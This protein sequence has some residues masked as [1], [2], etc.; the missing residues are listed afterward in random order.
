[1]GLGI[2]TASKSDVTELGISAGFGGRRG[3]EGAREMRSCAGE[4]R[5]FSWKA[6]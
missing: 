6:H 3:V 2:Y 1:M 4:I 5:D